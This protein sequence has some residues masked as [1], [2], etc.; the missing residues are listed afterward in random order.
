M[1]SAVCVVLKGLGDKR[2]GGNL[3]IRILSIFEVMVRVIHQQKSY[4]RQKR[5]YFFLNESS[6]FRSFVYPFGSMWQ[7][8]PAFTCVLIFIVVLLSERH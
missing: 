3:G 7:P 8:S 5:P 4:G 1:P 6:I 2:E